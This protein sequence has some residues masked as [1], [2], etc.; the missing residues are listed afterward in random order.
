MNF[1]PTCESF[2][3]LYIDK[4]NDGKLSHKC[5][6]CGYTG[7]ITNSTNKE[8]VYTNSIES[9]S[10]DT[11]YNILNNK[12]I[13]KDPTLPR[14]NN[15]DC[16]NP[17]C[18]T[19]QNKNSLVILNIN[20]LDIPSLVAW[21]NKQ[22]KKLEPKAPDITIIVN[23][24]LNQ[25]D[26]CDYGEFHTNNIFYD[27]GDVTNK[28]TLISFNQDI[29]KLYNLFDNG[30]CQTNPDLNQFV[31]DKNGEIPYVHQICKKIV[32]IKYDSKNM[33]YMYICS[34][35]GTSWKNIT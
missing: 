33:Q 11:T 15:I 21:I 18:L 29:D 2:L 31:L 4:D 9:Q 34:T 20:N 13:I 14:L 3:Y 16:I 28:T 32:F 19:K 26:M 1:C 5:K 30:N 17:K 8:Y 12:F 7:E 6:S 25:T 24:K 22:Y 27:Y 35:C 10:L 23:R